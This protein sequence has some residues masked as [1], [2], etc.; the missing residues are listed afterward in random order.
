MVCGLEGGV[1]F[2]FS[3]GRLPRR[4]VCGVCDGGELGPGELSFCD[5]CDFIACG[6][7]MVWRI[8]S[9]GLGKVPRL[10]LVVGC[11]LMVFHALCL[12]AFVPR[13]R[14]EASPSIDWG[15]VF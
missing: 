5:L 1:L 10:T 14:M 2:V 15:G 11:G 6:L 9:C 4:G 3:A 13:D 12:G 7:A 8:V